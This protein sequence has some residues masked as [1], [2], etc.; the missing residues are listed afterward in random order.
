MC[1]CPKCQRLMVRERTFEK[2]SDFFLSNA[3]N[4]RANILTCGANPF[5]ISQ[6]LPRLKILNMFYFLRCH[7]TCFTS[8]TD[9][10][11]AILVFDLI[12]CGVLS[13]INAKLPNSS[14]VILKETKFGSGCLESI[15]YWLNNI[16]EIF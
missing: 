12:G 5:F 8:I 10:L 3:E 11:P 16:Y 13:I 4:I 14:P 6:L 9:V 15:V 7:M 1:I 2:F